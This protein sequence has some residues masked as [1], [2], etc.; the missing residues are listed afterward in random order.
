MKPKINPIKIFIQ[1]IL[2]YII[3]SRSE[4]FCA[5]LVDKG[6]KDLLL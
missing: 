2:D 1:K 3:K 6:E 5:S 4:S